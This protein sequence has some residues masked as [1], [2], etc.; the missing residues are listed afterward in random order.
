MKL[1]LL[2]LLTITLWVACYYIN[3]MLYMLNKKYDSVYSWNVVYTNILI[4]LLVVPSVVY[5]IL[6]FV[7]TRSKVCENPPSWL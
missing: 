4:S 6:A 2:G 7:G 5:W 1:L 3:R